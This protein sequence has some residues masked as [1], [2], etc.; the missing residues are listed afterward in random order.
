MS[1]I[2]NNHFK[3][4][5]PTDWMDGSKYRQGSVGLVWT[6]E[7]STIFPSMVCADNGLVL[8]IQG[9][10]GAYS[11]PRDD[12]ADN[13][14]HFEISSP[15][16]IQKLHKYRAGYKCGTDPDSFWIYA[17]IPLELILEVI[18]IRGGLKEVGQVEE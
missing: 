4:F 1:D 18:E 11:Q 5:Y 13:Y 14:T 15:V 17:Y 7:E 6:G 16:F 9:H 8:S 3:K 10:H 12:F 2:I